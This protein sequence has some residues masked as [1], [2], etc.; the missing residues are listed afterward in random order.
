MLGIGHAENED[1]QFHAVLAKQH[2]LLGNGDGK[3][4]DKAGLLQIASDLYDAVTVCVGLDDGQKFR[5]GLQ[6]AL[7]KPDIL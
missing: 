1:R 5:F 7:G 2:A 6:P 3:H 4:I